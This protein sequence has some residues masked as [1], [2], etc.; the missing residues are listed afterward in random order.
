MGHPA[1]GG[2]QKR[3]VFE[4]GPQGCCSC[5]TPANRRGAVGLSSVHSRACSTRQL[6]RAVADTKGTTRTSSTGSSTWDSTLIVWSRPL[7]TTRSTRTTAET[8]CWK[9]RTWETSQHA[10]WA[11]HRLAGRNWPSHHAHQRRLPLANPTSLRL[12][13]DFSD[14]LLVHGWAWLSATLLPLPSRRFTRPS[15]GGG[16]TAPWAGAALP[17]PQYSTNSTSAHNS[18]S[19]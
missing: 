15:T 14:W 17:C 11:S 5:C 1:R 18:E 13:V 9:R 12:S 16:Q 19:G 7:C 3:Q 10:C 2:A 6:T 4:R 8:M